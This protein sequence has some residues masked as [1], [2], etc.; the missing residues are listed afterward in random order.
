MQTS[1]AVEQK[2]LAQ[3]ESLAAKWECEKNSALH[4]QLLRYLHDLSEPMTVHDHIVAIRALLEKDLLGSRFLFSCKLKAQS[5]TEVLR[6]EKTDG[7]A[8]GDCVRD[9]QLVGVTQLYE[10]LCDTI[11]KCRLNF[12]DLCGSLI[13]EVNATKDALVLKDNNRINQLE[14][15]VD[16][17]R[18]LLVK[19]ETHLNKLTQTKESLEAQLSGANKE[20]SELQQKLNQVTEDCHL[21]ALITHRS[22]NAGTIASLSLQNGLK[23]CFDLV[24]L[25]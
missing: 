10:Q 22:T 25:M 2:Y 18:N 3:I 11:E 23:N 24:Q 21:G 7:G 15:T 9:I 4:D 8:D 1:E 20:L 12:E 13:K 19:T 14:C 5:E 6:Q 16:D 17:T